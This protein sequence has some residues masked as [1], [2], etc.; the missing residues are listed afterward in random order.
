LFVYVYK[1]EIKRKEKKILTW[2]RKINCEN[3]YKLQCLDVYTEESNALV[4][5][6][7]Y[8]ISQTRIIPSVVFISKVHSKLTFSLG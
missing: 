8:Y 6:L 5:Y 4:D 1:P 3:N 7:N 2:E